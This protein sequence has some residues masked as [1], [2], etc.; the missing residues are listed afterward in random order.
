ML[1]YLIYVYNSDV[2]DIHMLLTLLCN[3]LYIR[4][5]NQEIFFV[6]EVN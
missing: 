5:I 2:V 6:Y 4:R 1:G 3:T